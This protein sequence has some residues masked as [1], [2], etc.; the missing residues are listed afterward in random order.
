MSFLDLVLKVARAL[1]RAGLRY[2]LVGGVACILFGVRRM[3]E[4]IDVVVEA[5][6]HDDAVKLVESL[7]LEGV[8]M[9]LGEVL[10]A[11]KG[12]GHA[13][14][15]IDCYRLDLKFAA[16]P[17][18]F[19]TVRDAVEVTIEGERVRVARLE[20]SI[21]AKVSVL[22]SLKDLEDALWLAIQYYDKVDW[23]RVRAL[24]GRDPEPLVEE[25]LSKIEREFPE[26]AAV[27]ERCA[28]L[29]REL[30]KLRELK[31]R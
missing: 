23:A 4:D 18:D 3:T 7:R 5:A 19:A 31:R 29:K 12:G 27:K 9:Q 28:F 30:A 17:L 2:A 8:A 20:D 16:S 6:G 24:L 13:T 22:C 10:S 26:S 15:F 25:L 14:A 11:L 21:A 1:E